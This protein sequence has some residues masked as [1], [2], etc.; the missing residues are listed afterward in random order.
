MGGVGSPLRHPVFLGALAVLVLNDHWGKP[1]FGNLL[2]GKL[3][4]VAGLV[5]FPVFLVALAEWAAGRRLPRLGLPA[6]AATALAFT[7]VKTWAPA[8]AAYEALY[9]A[10][11]W[12]LLAA[13]A[14]TLGAPTPGWPEIGAVM[15]PTDLWTLPAVG[16]GAWV[17][18]L[19]GEAH[20]DHS[21]RLPR[22]RSAVGVVG[23]GLHRLRPGPPAG[24]V[25]E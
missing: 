22:V 2:T 5:V 19:G 16:V 18:G 8:H 23:D 7:L 9:A 20:A 12:P 11:W 14:F 24:D 10:L 21:P 3:S 13:R 1:T 25:T 17:G 15:D 4:D 6:A